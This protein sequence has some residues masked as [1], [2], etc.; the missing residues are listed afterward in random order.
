MGDHTLHKQL[1]LVREPS[2]PVHRYSQALPFFGP[3]TG[4]S[5]DLVSLEAKPQTVDLPGE[6]VFLDLTGET[7]REARA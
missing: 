1:R 3:R 6:P 4:Q 2:T 5:V 7:R